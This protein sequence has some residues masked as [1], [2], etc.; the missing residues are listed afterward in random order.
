MINWAS[1]VGGVLQQ[2]VGMDAD[3][4]PA[5]TT[6]HFQQVAKVVPA[7][8]LTE[9]LAEALRSNQTPALGSV[10]ASLYSEATPDERAGILNALLAH[11]TPDAVETAKA[12]SGMNTGVSKLLQGNARLSSAD[13]SS[14]PAEFVQCLTSEVEKQ[15]ANV[16]D[17]LAAF[18]AEHPAVVKSLGPGALAVALSHIGQVAA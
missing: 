9:A 15:D 14:I 17:R 16:V 7:D 5:A 8:D 11:V 4:A 1:Q 12:R 2:Y 6:Q 3:D 18:C 13:A 10:V